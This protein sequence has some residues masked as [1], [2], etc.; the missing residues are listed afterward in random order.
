MEGRLVLHGER[1]D[2]DCFEMRDRSWS[3]RKDSGPVRAGYDYAV[4]G[5]GKAFLAM[6]MHAGDQDV[7]IAGYHLEGEDVV[8]LTGGRREVERSQGRPVAVRIEASDERGNELHAEGRCVNRYAFQSSPNYFAWM[9]LT[10]WSFEGT[11]A[12]GE[13]QDV[14]SPD[15]LRAEL[16]ERG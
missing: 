15:L 8:R 2:V 14:W 7:L 5:P 10:D 12:W 3:V 16:R 13:D 1:M 6:T 11:R 9:C 4:A